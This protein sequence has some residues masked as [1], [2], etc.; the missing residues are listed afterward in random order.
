M[1]C[2]KPRSNKV[3]PHHSK[4]LGLIDLM[5]GVV[6]SGIIALGF[7]SLIKTVNSSAQNLK[8][9]AKFDSISVLVKRAVQVAGSC[10][11]LFIGADSDPVKFVP[12]GSAD[13][14]VSVSQIGFDSREI[15]KVGE[16]SI[17]S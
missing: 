11:Q 1:I 3:S 10:D 8:A 17:W 13:Y 15:V 16:R 4:G 2:R 7:I 9:S 12:D 5:I 14:A 6:I